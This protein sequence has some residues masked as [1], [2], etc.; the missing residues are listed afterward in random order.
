MS[1]ATQVSQQDLVARLDRMSEQLTYLVE[2]QRKQEELISEMSPI[3]KEVMK[4]ATARLDTL[5]KK[6]YFDFGKEVLSLG[7][8]V[9]ESYSPDDV[10]KLAD[11]IVGIL[12]TV[13]AMTQPEVLSIADQATAVLQKADQAEPV[14]ILGVVRASRDDDVQKG[15]AVMLEVLRHVGRGAQLIAEQ[16]KKTTTA[17]EQRRQRLAEMTRSKKESATKSKVLG[18]ERASRPR[19]ALNVDDLPPPAACAVPAT[20][21]P[22]VAATIDGLGFTADGHLANADDWTKDL[23]PKLATALGVVLSD[24][25]WK[26]IDFARADFANTNVSPNVRRLTTGTG[27]STKDLYAL[28]PKA[29]A[30]TLAK[31]AGLPKPAGC[32]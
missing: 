3:L 19:V 24:D 22:E 29:P 5:D 23:A 25:H 14:G 1:Q 2:R 11:A 20:T 4:T 26:L 30:R 7:E 17:A 10:R 32:I 21:K 9:I 13:R 8:R 18:V 16:K 15:M 27:L 28:F 12:D 6:G 31:I